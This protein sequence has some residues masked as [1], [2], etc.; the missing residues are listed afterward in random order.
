[1]EGFLGTKYTSS[2]D[3][4]LAAAVTLQFLQECAQLPG[5]VAVS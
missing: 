4:V 3:A 2:S 1:M 5:A